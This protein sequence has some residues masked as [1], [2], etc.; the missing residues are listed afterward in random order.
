[1]LH[2]RQPLLWVPLLVFVLLAALACGGGGR[3]ATPVPPSPTAAPAVT[4]G[5]GVSPTEVKLGMTSDLT[6]VSGIRYASVVAA[7]QA[8]FQKVNREDSGACDRKITLLAEDDL[9]SPDI[10]LEKTKKLIEQDQV[11]AIV[12]ALGTAVHAAAAPYLN[13][14]NA[15]GDTADGIPDLYVSTGWSGWGDTAKL[16]WTIGHIP[17]YLG[18]A[19][20]LTT[21]INGNLP[22][23]KVGI[24]YQNDPFG[25]DYLNG[26]KGALADPALLVAEQP[27]DAAASDVSV[28]LLAIRD[29][30]AEVVVLASTPQA[31]ASAILTAAAQGYAPQWVISYVNAHTT[32]ASLLGGGTQPEQLAQGFQQLAG[33]VTTNYLLSA[34]EDAD[35]PALVDHKRVMETYDG[36]PVSTL[37]IY[38]Q[39]LAELIVETLGRACDD[40]TRSGLLRAAESIQGFRTS[41]LWPGIQINLSASD[42]Y[43]IQALQLV[44]IG[45]DGVL[46]EIGAPV[47]VE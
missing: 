43:A 13:D 21:Y 40:L 2:R 38:G 11:L 23:K 34:V 20:V 4:A 22:G 44:R 36:P 46:E 27:Y 15:D 29:A 30:G 1:M 26:L 12:G 5:P 28:Q 18:D 19:R 7:M 45:A 3:Q 39:S 8:Y 47:S 16:P 42:H 10:A 17:D 32:L 33:A 14:P 35:D 31:S 37:S 25:M 6:G 9:Y 24:L 41:V